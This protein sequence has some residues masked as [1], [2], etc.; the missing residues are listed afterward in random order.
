MFQKGF[1][2]LGYAIVPILFFAQTTAAAPLSIVY[3]NNTR[4]NVQVDYINALANHPMKVALTSALLAAEVANLPIFVTDDNRSVIDYTA[5]IGKSENYSAALNDSAV[6]HATAPLATQQMNADG[7]VTP[8]ANSF[9]FTT[10]SD[11]LGNTIVNVTVTAQNVT[12]VT[13]NG[14]A[15]TQVGTSNVWSAG[16]TGSVTV[17]SSEITLTTGN[18]ATTKSSVSVTALPSNVN[19]V[20]GGSQN[21]TLTA[22]DAYG[23]PIPNR[24]IY[25]QPGIQGLW[26]TQVNG[27][28]ITGLVNFNIHEDG[29]YSYSALQSWG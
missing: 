3:Q 2:A 20:I 27:Q 23:S 22:E 19:S 6:N 28:T 18:T 15:A 13:V 11:L 25:L 8:I 9:T 16:L 7:S 29:Q 14:T 5:A 24:T 26:I 1:K 21:I 10:T 4:Q 12:G 17:A